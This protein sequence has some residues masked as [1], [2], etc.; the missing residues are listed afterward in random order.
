MPTKAIEQQQWLKKGIKFP[1][2][3]N[4]SARNL[5]DDRCVNFLTQQVEKYQIAAGMLELEITETALMQDPEMA[6]KLLHR[7]AALGVKLSI[8]DF[9]TGYSSLKNLSIF[10]IDG[11][12]IDRASKRRVDVTAQS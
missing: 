8:D 2:S 1:V 7:I 3:V 5:I 11:I 4:L 6:N 9:G 10:P 12:K